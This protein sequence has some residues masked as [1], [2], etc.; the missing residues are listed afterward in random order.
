MLSATAGAVI[1]PTFPFFKPAAAADEVLFCFPYAGSGGTIFRR[2]NQWL[3][4]ELTICAVE[5]PGRGARWRAPLRPRVLDLAAEIGADI[6]RMG[7][8]RFSFYGHSLGGL[9]AFETARYLRRRAGLGP[10]RLVVSGSGAPQIPN[11]NQLFH[12]LDDRALVAALIRYNG[13]PTPVLEYPDLLNHLLPVVRADLAAFETYQYVEEAP[14]D[15]P[16][17]SYGGREDPWIRKDRIEGWAR[18]TKTF[19]TRMFTGDHFFLNAEDRAMLRAL[20]D[21]LLVDVEGR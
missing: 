20:A 17:F 11:P 13:I 9:V 16:I 14:L 2:W 21:D 15:C 7:T 1:P 4:P 8:E 3:P 18:Q 10:R 6:L 19:R 12:V 5:Y